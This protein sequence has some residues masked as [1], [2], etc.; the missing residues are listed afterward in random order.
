[1]ISWVADLAMLYI[2]ISGFAV[3]KLGCWELKLRIVR[4]SACLF[5]ISKGF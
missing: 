2:R 5:G 4:S 1:M 3:S